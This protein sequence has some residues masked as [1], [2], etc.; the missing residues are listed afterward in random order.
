MHPNL[1]DILSNQEVPIDNKLLADYLSGN[2]ND[3]E[4]HALEKKLMEGEALE[5]DAMDGWQQAGPNV[6]MLRHAEEI[7]RKLQKQLHPPPA[8]KR[9]KIITD[10]P[11]MWLVFGLLFALVVIAW[12]IISRLS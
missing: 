4:R 10:L 7:N 5:Q 11:V 9:K 6:D 8:R 2:L 3:A 1:L 12:F